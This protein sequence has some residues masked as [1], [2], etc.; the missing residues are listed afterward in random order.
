MSEDIKLYPEYQR[1]QI[2]VFTE[3][4][5]EKQKYFNLFRLMLN[6]RIQRLINYPDR[7]EFITD[8]FEF[9]FFTKQ[10]SARGYK[11]HFVI[12]LTQDEDFH[13]CIV[14]PITVIHNYLTEDE[15]WKELF[16]GL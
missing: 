15:K 10:M 12:N 13:N 9:R 8:K 2:I 3:N 6:D 1:V 7:K 11:A 16:E 5:K 4:T 14:E